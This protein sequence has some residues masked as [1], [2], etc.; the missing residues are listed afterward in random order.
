M[1]HALGDLEQARDHY[2]RGLALAA[3]VGDR[4]QE[5]NERCNLGLLYQE[6]GRSTDAREQFELALS[7]AREMGHTRLAYTVLCNLGIVLTSES[8][9][10]EAAQHLDQAVKGAVASSDL[11]SE[12]QFRA[13]LALVQARQGQLHEARESIDRGEGLLLASADRLSLALLL[14]DRAEIELLASQPGAAEAAIRRARR[15]ADELNC[16]PES[17]LR[18]RMAAINAKLP[19]A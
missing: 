15:I 11:H 8:R 18:R 5:G 7:A 3:E 16:G 14:C 9:L 1:H 17:E 13:Y 12:G 4:R 2:E 6:Q 19:F 10:V